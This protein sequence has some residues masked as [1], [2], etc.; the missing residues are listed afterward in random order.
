MSNSFTAD[1]TA[2]NAAPKRPGGGAMKWS[3][4]CERV[5]HADGSVRT[6]PRIKGGIASGLSPSRPR[7]PSVGRANKIGVTHKGSA[8]PG[9]KPGSSQDGSSRGGSSAK[10]S[11]SSSREKA[12][13]GE[14]ESR[15]S[16]GCWDTNSSE[17]SRPR[18]PPDVAPS[19]S[20]SSA[21]LMP[22]PMRTGLMLPPAFIDDESVHV[23]E[24]KTEPEG[25]TVDE[26]P[27]ARAFQNP[28]EADPRGGPV[29]FKWDPYGRDVPRMQH[30]EPHSETSVEKMVKYL[31][32]VVEAFDS[33]MERKKPP[34]ADKLD[35]EIARMMGYLHRQLKNAPK[36]HKLQGIFSHCFQRIWNFG[37]NKKVRSTTPEE[38]KR[39]LL[40]LI[41]NLNS[42][43]PA[44]RPA[45][46]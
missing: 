1:T 46:H 15:C 24:N 28:M 8:G 17:Q 6:S 34:T 44:R 38:M 41:D 20:G 29:S 40:D 39:I 32:R 16:S 14:V 37:A 21:L 19:P 36:K 12:Y 35:A 42:E 22:E 33:N 30:R 5:Q 27:E 9:K 4:V 13:D 25:S 31:K 45:I 3:E 10:S 23:A 18:T 43:F 7:Q 2:V 26:E 11:R